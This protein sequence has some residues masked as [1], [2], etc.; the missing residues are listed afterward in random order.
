VYLEGKVT[1][2]DS[3]S[4]EHQGP[5]AVLNAVERLA[6]GYR[7][8]SDRTRQDLDIAQAQLRDYQVKV[9]RPLSHAGYLD[10]LVALRDQ[11]KLGLSGAEPQEG[12]PSVAELA[13]QIKALKTAHTVEAAPQRP[14]ARR[15]SAEEPVTARTLRRAEDSDEQGGTSHVDRLARE[16]RSANGRA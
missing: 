6:K 13:E 9:G 14:A 4:R 8:E 7:V 10:Q 5:R 1:R 3:L 11:L 16:R 2:Q 12:S 15:T